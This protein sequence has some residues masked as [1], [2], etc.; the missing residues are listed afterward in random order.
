MAQVQITAAGAGFSIIGGA[1]QLVAP[2]AFFTGPLMG[3][4]M[5]ISS[6]PALGW[7]WGDNLRQDAYG[8]SMV[9]D[10]RYER[11]PPVIKSEDSRPNAWIYV[12]IST[13]DIGGFV[14]Q[15]KEVVATQ[16]DIP[17]GYTIPPGGFLLV[18][19]D[20]EPSQNSPALGDLHADLPSMRC[21]GY[22][23]VWEAMDANGG[24]E[25]NEIQLAECR[26]RGV[27]ATRQLAKRQITWFRHL[28][29]C[30]PVSGE[31]TMADWGAT[32]E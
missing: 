28:S 26:E 25:L 13:S 10:I 30:Q 11:G 18:W 8:M 4:S 7:I 16:V 14:Q 3:S 22:R 6:D 2:D 5:M 21:V 24:A 9:A 23:Q 17:P 29:G 31:L 19:A 20:E 32:M 12:D 15:A 1:G 27:A